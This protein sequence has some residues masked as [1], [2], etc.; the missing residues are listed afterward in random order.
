LK[1]ENKIVESFQR[2]NGFAPEY[3][4]AISGVG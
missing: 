4:N 3:V 2:L 1:I